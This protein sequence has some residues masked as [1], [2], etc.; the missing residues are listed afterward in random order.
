MTELQQPLD[1]SYGNS[2]EARIKAMWFTC[3]TGNRDLWEVLGLVD[4]PVAP[5]T[6]VVRN[7]RSYCPQCDKRVGA[8]G[9]CFTC[10]PKKRGEDE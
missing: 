8:G 10:N 5:A 1:R 2:E 7:G 4:E 9:Y 6:F 3:R